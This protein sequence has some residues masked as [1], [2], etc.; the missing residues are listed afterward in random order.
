MKRRS[1]RSTAFPYIP[2]DNTFRFR[3]TDR[4][5][6]L[7]QRTVREA[8][9]FPNLSLNSLI[10]PRETL[11]EKLKEFFNKDDVRHYFRNE[12]ILELAN[13]YQR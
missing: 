5:R 4:L 1:Q 13:L 3:S 8:T 9:E 12:M 10:H 6:D 7:E 2:E 11:F